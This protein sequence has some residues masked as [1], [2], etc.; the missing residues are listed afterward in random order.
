MDKKDDNKK[1]S[2]D[3]KKDKKDKKDKKKKV[4]KKKSDDKISQSQIVNIK[5][6][7]ISK[8]KTRT[9]RRAAPK[10][11]PPPPPQIQRQLQYLPSLAGQ[12]PMIPPPL[13]PAPTPPPAPPRPPAP[14]PAAEPR[15]TG[16]FFSDTSESSVF[17]SSFDL[18]SASLDDLTSIGRGASRPTMTRA[19]NRP[20][21]DSGVS[22][23]TD[24]TYADFDNFSQF[25]NTPNSRFGATIDFDEAN[26]QTGLT[27]VDDPDPSIAGDITFLSDRTF[28]T[29]ASPSL[30]IISEQL[31]ALASFEDIA[32]PSAAQ[33]EDLGSVSISSMS[34][35]STPNINLLS[36][37]VPKSGQILMIEAE[38]IPPVQELQPTQT[39]PEAQPIEAQLVEPPVVAVP[40]TEDDPRISETLQ[41]QAAVKGDVKPEDEATGGGGGVPPFNFTEAMK[42]PIQQDLIFKR[43]I[44]E[45]ALYKKNL[46]G[47]VKSVVAAIKKYNLVTSLGTPLHQS[48]FGRKYNE[49]LGKSGRQ[50]AINKLSIEDLIAQVK[51][52]KGKA[53][54][55]SGAAAESPKKEAKKQGSGAAAA[56][57][58]G[59]AKQVSGAAAES[60]VKEAKKQGSGAAAESPKG[61]AKQ[62][63]GAAAKSPVK[64]G[65]KQVSKKAAKK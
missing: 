54:Q 21:S 15:R 62:G 2:K 12:A 47:G 3:K 32:Q 5:I 6:G 61:K 43:F 27:D 7:D 59:E 22:A 33:T 8:P 35:N 53:K 24:P 64:K 63:S 13:T 37:N 29:Q 19:F 55:G 34:T 42:D 31:G 28:E 65:G 14:A 52:A 10:A 45:R 56:S 48:E 9:R 38:R 11:A 17:G 18:A 4:V 60:P 16:D 26:T 57:P 25:D 58:K 20:R 50:A 44:L 41:E 46:D 23:M 40:V 39:P 36:S 1:P 49:W 51:E 30:P